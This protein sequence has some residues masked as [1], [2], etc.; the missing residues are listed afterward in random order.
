MVTVLVES[1]RTTRKILVPDSMQDFL[2]DV[3]HKMGLLTCARRCFDLEGQP[4][5]S[6]TTMNDGQ[7]VVVSTTQRFQK[8]SAQRLAALLGGGGSVR[9]SGSMR[10]RPGSSARKL[11]GGS[12]SARLRSSR[13]VLASPDVAKVL[14][15]DYKTRGAALDAAPPGVHVEL[16]PPG[17]HQRAAVAL[18]AGVEL[19]VE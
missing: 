11:G 7:V 19:E 14:S 13:S 18:A 5:R 6:V 17:D 8:P 3:T 9:S 2:D 15:K 16:I 1:S 12:S 4:M 10:Q